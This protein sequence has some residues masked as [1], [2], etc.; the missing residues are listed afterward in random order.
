MPAYQIAKF[1]SLP[2]EARPVVLE[3][4]WLRDD[5]TAAGSR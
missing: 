4:R 1:L 3:G 5:P 2:A